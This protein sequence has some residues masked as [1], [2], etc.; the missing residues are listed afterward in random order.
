MHVLL[1]PVRAALIAMLFAVVSPALAQE[2]TNQAIARDCVQDVRAVSLNTVSDV[3]DLSETGVARIADL[4]AAGAP[5]RD[6]VAAGVEINRR[7][8]RR[9]NAGIDRIG[10]L[11][12]DCVR[13]LRDNDA[14][15]ELIAWVVDKGRDARQA[16]VRAREA[17]QARVTRAV[18]Q[19]VD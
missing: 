15:P 13:T 1:S 16:S 14:A 19:A 10:S 9:A 17:A 12:T 8:E 4:E 7:I 5:D 2:D 11:I 3:R 6:I 18:R